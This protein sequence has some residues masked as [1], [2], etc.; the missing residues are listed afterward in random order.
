[1]EEVE[2][3]WT[4]RGKECTDSGSS[5]LLIPDEDDV[6]AAV[7]LAALSS[8]MHSTDLTGFSWLALDSSHLTTV[9]L[10]L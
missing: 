3:S 5:S 2:L 9:P 1:M 8:V 4:F 10:L 6:E 7:V